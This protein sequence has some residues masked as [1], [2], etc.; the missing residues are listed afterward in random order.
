MF[1]HWGLLA[2]MFTYLL[3]YLCKHQETIQ[4]Q[5]IPVLVP[6]AFVLLSSTD[7]TQVLL[8]IH[9]G[10]RSPKTQEFHVISCLHGAKPKIPET[11]V[12]RILYP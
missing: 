12:S 4:L 9:V 10:W 7:I 11:C 8:I 3:L 5:S 2:T 1:W 6:E